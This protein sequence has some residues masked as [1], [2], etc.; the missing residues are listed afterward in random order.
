MTESGYASDPGG[1]VGS[2]A[3]TPLWVAS[4]SALNDL[5]TCELLFTLKN[6]ERVEGGEDTK[7]RLIGTAVH[8]S[9]AA[10]WGGRGEPEEALRFVFER[11]LALSFLKCYA[12]LRTPI[13]ENSRILVVEEAQSS[14]G[15][16]GILDLAL[17]DSE[18]EIV[19]DHKTTGSGITGAWAQQW[20]HSET[21]AGYAA[22]RNTNRVVVDAIQIPRSGLFRLEHFGWYE[23]DY[24]AQAQMFKELR[25]AKI[26]RAVALVGGK[27]RPKR[28]T[29]SCYRYNR[30]CEFAPLCFGAEEEFEATLHRM[31]ESGELKVRETH[32]QERPD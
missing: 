14:G 27:E 1:G 20:Q 2:G 29:R 18:G 10:W 8:E 11:P 9:L 3:A 13:R 15:Y 26:A 22:L 28:N 25:G 19:V 30:L 21:L 12:S 4:G 5:D 24:A 32:I 16:G 17:G 31:M 7:A 6:R 23:F